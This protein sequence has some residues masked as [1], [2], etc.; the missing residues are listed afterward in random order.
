MTVTDTDLATVDH[1]ISAHPLNPVQRAYLAGASTGFEL[2]GVSTHGYFELQGRGPVDLDRLRRSL[3]AVIARHEM[4]RASID[5]DAGAVVIADTVPRFPLEVCDLRHLG[6]DAARSAVSGLRAEHSTLVRPPEAWPLFGVVVV[7]LADD[8]LTIMIDV[9]GL[10]VDLHSLKVVLGDVIAAYRREPLGPA[11]PQGT[12]AEIDRQIA[13]PDPVG[14][15]YW[16]GRLDEIAPPPR[17]PLRRSPAAV[18]PAR[19]A[20][21]CH[22]LSAG[23]WE[24]ATAVAAA[25]GLS[26]S[27]LG[28]AALA[29]TL[30]RWAA[31]STFTVIVPCSNRPPRHRGARD[32]VG[33]FASFVP[34]TVEWSAPTLAARATGLQRRLLQAATRGRRAG[35]ALMAKLADRHR[36]GGRSLFPVVYTSGLGLG[37]GATSH[38]GW[39]LTNAASQTAQVYLDAQLTDTGDGVL[40]HWDTVDDVLGDETVDA[41]FADHVADIER[42]IG[43]PDWSEETATPPTPNVPQELAWQPLIRPTAPTERILCGAW[44]HAFEGRPVGITDRLGAHGG[45]PRTARL[46]EARLADWF[47]EHLVPRSLLLAHET[48]ESQAAALPSLIPGITEIAELSLAAAELAGSPRTTPI[49]PTQ[50]GGVR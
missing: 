18:G 38:P 23:Q 36:A 17:L 40:V 28:A 2:G 29:Q 16:Q 5:V 26:P 41:M 20:S 24:R 32:A 50:T 12:V 8:E 6:P 10:V 45:G 35:P 47:G 34:V 42:M 14:D 44:Q 49:D 48:V 39:R 43:S 22:H 27:A 11:S 1:P 13:L 7:L 30:S 33:Q 3:D 21:R 9:D 31:Q 15:D 37:A 46:A 19:F 25:N 4:L